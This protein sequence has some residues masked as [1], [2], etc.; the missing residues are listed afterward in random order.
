MASLWTK[1]TSTFSGDIAFLIALLVVI[2][3]CAMYFGKNRIA[4]IILTFYPAVFLYK[5]F[6]YTNKFIYL[7]GDRGVAI[8][9]IAIFLVFFIVINFV[10]RKYID[11]FAESGNM[12]HKAG[13][14]VAVLILIL[15]FSY[16]VVSLDT[17]HNFSNSI[18][19]LF[20]S[21]LIFWWSLAPLAI[22]MFV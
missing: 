4:S 21:N 1:I 7:S 22:L 3:L 9:K 12:F 10:V 16:N 14:S 2:F 8:N 11:L 6:P 17:L 20:N 18:D 5:I 19:V 15:L 13:L